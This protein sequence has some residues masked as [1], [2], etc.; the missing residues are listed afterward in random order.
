[1]LKD[2]KFVTYVPIFLIERKNSY[3]YIGSVPPHTPQKDIDRY[4]RSQMMKEEVSNVT[5]IEVGESV[6]RVV[7]N[8]EHQYYEFQLRG[9]WVKA[10]DFL[11]YLCEDIKVNWVAIEDGRK[12]VEM[13][14]KSVESHKVLSDTQ[15]ALRWELESNKEIPEE[16]YLHDNE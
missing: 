2:L 9:K 4:M 14:N 16:K 8:G 13:I 12:A 5:F 15:A 6:D 7:Y 11:T 10:S 1:M 3:P